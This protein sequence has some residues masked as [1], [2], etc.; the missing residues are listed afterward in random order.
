MKTRFDGT[1]WI[2]AGG[3][4]FRPAEMGTDHLL[5]T[6]KMLKNRPG[7]VIAMVVRDIEATPDCC[8]FDPFGGGHSELVKQSLFNIT[9]L[10]PE[11]VS[12]YALNSPLG[13]AMKA[14]LL[15]RG[16]NVENYLSMIEGPET[17][18]HRITIN[19][20]THGNAGIG[21]AVLTAEHFT[22]VRVC[23]QCTGFLDFV[24]VQVG[25]TGHH[26]LERFSIETLGIKLVVRHSSKLPF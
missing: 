17:L 5:N 7:V 2:G 10:S 18:V 9:S 6:V 4:A 13:M 11:Q 22:N 23:G 25:N 8:P 26:V 14:E 16:V 24:H 21:G 19:Q 1:L 15:S 12:D 3:Q 20:A